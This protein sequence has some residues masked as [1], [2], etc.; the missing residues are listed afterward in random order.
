MSVAYHLAGGLTQNQLQ[1]C[2]DL[3]KSILSEIGLRI[4]HEEILAFLSRQ[5]GARVEGGRVFYDGDLFEKCLKDQRQQNADYVW[6]WPDEKD[7]TL[8]P[9]YMCLN[10]YDA[11]G[12]GMH[13]STT[14]DL[15]RAAKLCD[16]YDMAGPSPVHPQ[17][18]PVALRQI[19][20]SRICIENSRA[21]GKWMVVGDIEELR[22]ICGMS[23]L[24]GRTPPYV[25]LQITI[26]PL[27]LNAEYL[28][29]I[30]RLRDS[31]ELAGDVTIGGGS[32]PMLGATG[33]LSLPAAWTQ[34]AAEAIG[35][36]ITAKLINPRVLGNVCF[37]VFPFDMRGLGITM[38]TPEGALSRLV[39]KQIQEKLFSRTMAATFASMGLPL[40]PQSTAERMSNVLV[41]ALA[42]SRVFYDAGMAPID[43]MFCPEQVVLDHEIV[44]W[45]QRFMRGMEFE[46]D[47]EK[48]LGAI[49]EGMA[50]G[51]FFMQEWTLRH[52]DFY[53]TP[54]LFSYM[55]LSGYMAE[56]RKTL[57]ERAREIADERIRSHHFRLPQDALAGIERVFEA[58]AEKLAK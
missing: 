38:G 57:V 25:V 15:I 9:A 4:D 26:S 53:W 27:K 46:G 14:D 42:G 31:P 35:A 7:F 23:R 58:T 1:E 54:E 10:V 20:T 36:Y 45:I 55:T 52:R 41:E 29:I 43:D 30:W 56:K 12:G 37:Q 21:V 51:G 24:A 34:A 11:I 40:D 13:R 33:P 47:K 50:D 2:Q 8:R 48:I 17:N 49:R 6:Q 3:A 28:D 32:I 44:K 19:I 5:K 22:C 18:A 39:G 16:S